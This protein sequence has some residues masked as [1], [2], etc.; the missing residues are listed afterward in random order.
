VSGTW[1]FYANTGLLVILWWLFRV[2]KFTTAAPDEFFSQQRWTI[3]EVAVLLI[4]LSAV[5]FFLYP[6]M[7]ELVSDH[8]SHWSL[9]LGVWILPPLFGLV[10]IW[11]FFSYI[12]QPVSAAGLSRKQSIRFTL[13]GAR[14]ILCILALVWLVASFAPSVEQANPFSNFATRGYQAVVERLG[15]F[16]AACLFFLQSLWLASL[17]SISEEVGYTGLLY[18]ALRKHLTARSAILLTATS[19]MMAHGELNV[20]PFGLGL[21]GMRLLEKY[22]SLIPAIVIH[23]G[24]D[25]SRYVDLWFMGVLSVQRTAYLQTVVAIAICAFLV[26]TGV[27][28]YILE[29]E[30]ST[31]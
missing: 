28:T 17:T 21:I 11:A 24:W 13:A 29:R 8:Q 16:A 3:R 26:V 12:G 6:P 9:R 15:L 10:G 14:W 19:F 1:W 27:S 31:S 25:L 23:F 4:I 5:R 20:V 22:H 2:R 18:G 7:A 30:T